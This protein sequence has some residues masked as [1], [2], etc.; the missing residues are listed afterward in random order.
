[1][2]KKTYRLTNEEKV[3]VRDLNHN[4]VLQSQN[5]FQAIPESERKYFRS[6]VLDIKHLKERCLEA[7]KGKIIRRVAFVSDAIV[8]DASLEIE[9]DS[10]KSGS[11]FLRLVID[12]THIDTG[13]QYVLAKDM[14][15]IAHD[16][17]LEKIIAKF[18]RPQKD[19]MDIY[20][21]L[22]FRM[23]GV[24]PDYVHDQEGKEQDM[25]VM[26]ASLDE[27]RKAQQFIGDWLDNGHGAVGAGEM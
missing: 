1:M 24:L 26:Q 14:Y 10:W 9:T 18:M 7:E 25:V 23:E 27:M 8:G 3:T 2:N 11:A 21:K 5:F 12:P 22:G 16:Q 19:L 15:D 6:D 13:V 17:H 20:Q 4:D